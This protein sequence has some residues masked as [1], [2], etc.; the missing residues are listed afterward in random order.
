MGLRIDTGGLTGRCSRRAAGRQ[1][2][3]ASSSPLAAERQVVR[4]HHETARH[5]D[6]FI[7]YAREDSQSATRLYEALLDIPAVT[8][9]LDS[10]K[11]L[12]G[13]KWKLEI[14]SALKSCDLVVVLLSRHSVSKKGFVQRE[15]VE[16]LDMMKQFPPDRLFLIPAR[17]D[18]CRPQHPELQELQWVDLFPDWNSG[19]QAILKSINKRT[20]QVAPPPVSS[21]DV[22][23]ETLTSAAAFTRR[24]R[25]RQ[26]LRGC[27]AM[28]LVFDSE[29]FRGS[30]LAGANLVRCR[31]VRCDFRGCN[32]KGVNFEGAVFTDCQIADAD[33]WGVNFWGA[34]V[35]G[36]TDLA[37]ARLESTNFFA[38]RLSPDQKRLLENDQKTV[39]LGDYGTFVRYFSDDLG[40]GSDGF[41]HTFAWINHR[42]FRLMFSK[43]RPRAL[44]TFLNVEDETDDT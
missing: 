16:A 9:W 17:L 7:S 26:E 36:I 1:V 11:L 25:E 15:I 23:V 12:P 27:D 6:V 38:T 21:A 34:D 2:E 41:A 4:C 18:D 24:L 35:R 19:W 10:K 22:V 39:A 3:S 8:P 33:L 42:Y 29:S 43:D 5:M 13:T 30:D 40:M 14:M 31:F 32:L 20:G 28:A 44:R 37:K